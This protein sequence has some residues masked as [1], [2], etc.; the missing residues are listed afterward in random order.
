MDRRLLLELLPGI[1]FLI[2]N[3]IGDLFWGAGAAVVATGVA[4]A[5]RWRW[6][7]RVPWLAVA[8]LA[9]ALALALASVAL[10]DAA[11]VFLRPTI[12]AL[13]FAAILALGA[14]PRPPLLER[15]LGYRIRMRE[16]GWHVLH[17]AWTVLAL[18][19]AAA[20]ELARRAL[21]VD[22]WAIYNA[23]SDPVLV[24]LLWL[25]TRLVAERYWNEREQS[26]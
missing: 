2:G 25:A 10:R 9:L 11:F 14:L 22:G 4:V 19:S 26:R 20:N 8:T 21:S 16:P 13:A 23:L 5:L 17:A 15:S 18:G 1:A 12:G 7:G 3:A 24:A 6:D